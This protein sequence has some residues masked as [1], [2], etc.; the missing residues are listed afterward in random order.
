[1]EKIKNFAKTNKKTI[2][3][4][5]GIL[6]LTAA[7]YAVY[8]LKIQEVQVTDALEAVGEAVESVG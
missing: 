6:I 5:G 2:M 3:I 8:K 1:M 4:V 7:G